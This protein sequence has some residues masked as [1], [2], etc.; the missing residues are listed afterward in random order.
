MLLRFTT[1]SLGLNP[2]I[3][4]FLFLDIIDVYSNLAFE[5][6]W[7]TSMSL[8]VAYLLLLYSL[9]YNNMAIRITT[10]RNIGI[11]ILYFSFMN[12]FIFSPLNI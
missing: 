12:F 3:T 9:V 8:L 7:Y 11:N 2:K 5:K 1:S 10:I 6:Y 4:S